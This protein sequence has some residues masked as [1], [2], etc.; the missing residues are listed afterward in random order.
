MVGL[1]AANG[2]IEVEFGNAANLAIAGE[3]LTFSPITHAGSI[4]WICNGSNTLAE[5]Y[6]PPVCRN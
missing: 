1:N 3:S 5:K 4:E 2:I 6:V